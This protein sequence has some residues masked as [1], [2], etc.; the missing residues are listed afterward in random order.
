[1]LGGPRAAVVSTLEVCLGRVCAVYERRDA[2]FVMTH[3]AGPLHISVHALPWT[4][5]SAVSLR[6][7]P[8]YKKADLFRRLFAKQ[9]RG[10]LP[11]P[12]IRIG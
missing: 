9:Y 11:T 10:V 7:R 1:V 2:G 5:V 4:R 8:T 12:R 6:A 3:P